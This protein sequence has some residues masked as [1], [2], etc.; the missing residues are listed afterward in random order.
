MDST[1][2]NKSGST[3]D[4]HFHLWLK[5]K[6]YHQSYEVFW[7]QKFGYGLKSFNNRSSTSA[8]SQIKKR[9]ENLE[10]DIQILHGCSVKKWTSLPSGEGGGLFSKFLK[11]FSCKNPIPLQMTKEKILLK[12][13]VEIFCWNFL[14]IFFENFLMK[15]FLMNNY[16]NQST[17][18]ILSQSSTLHWLSNPFFVYHLELF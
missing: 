12:F 7:S 16:I 4:D 11:F 17:L 3:F 2:E 9:C 1:K 14:L 13:F 18:G 8:L 6:K 5:S 15:F 10:D